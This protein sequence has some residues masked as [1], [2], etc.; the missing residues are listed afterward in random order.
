MSETL[1]A[2]VLKGIIF[3]S[4]CDDIGV[5]HAEVCKED[6]DKAFSLAKKYI[7]AG[8]GKHLMPLGTFFDYLLSA[9]TFTDCFSEG[10]ALDIFSYRLGNLI[11]SKVS[12]ISL[13]MLILFG[14]NGDFILQG[15]DEISK[16]YSELEMRNYKLQIIDGAG[17]NYKNCEKALGSN[18][19]NWI[20][21]LIK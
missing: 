7:D 19:V 17:H 2:N 8:D 20:K 21:G 1:Y 3:I 11:S 15:L 18:I 5:Y 16:M 12:G 9:T 6:R 10:S 14:N 13:P 4:P